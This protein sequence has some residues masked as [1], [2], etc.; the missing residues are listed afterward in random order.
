M[1][2]EREAIELGIAMSREI[3]EAQRHHFGTKRYDERVRALESAPKGPQRK[4]RMGW[5]RR[6]RE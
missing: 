5:L 4:V 3:E 1:T 2:P 6:L